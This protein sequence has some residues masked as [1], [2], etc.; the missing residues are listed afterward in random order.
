VWLNQGDVLRIAFQDGQVSYSRN[1]AVFYTSANSPVFPLRTY[2]AL[3]SAGSAVPDV[4][5]SRQ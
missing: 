1:G 3:Y 4:R 2:A 5:M